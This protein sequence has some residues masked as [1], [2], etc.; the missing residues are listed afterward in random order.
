MK[1]APDNKTTWL[2]FIDDAT[3]TVAISALYKLIRSPIPKIENS[4]QINL[5][6]PEYLGYIGPEFKSIPPGTGR[7][8]RIELKYGTNPTPPSQTGG[9]SRRGRRKI[10]K[11]KSY[12]KKF[13]R[14][15]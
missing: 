2:Y 6:G 5:I 11:R 13:G 8:Y 7:T 15:R 12:K 9:R 1:F 10:Y 14:R 3:N 4:T